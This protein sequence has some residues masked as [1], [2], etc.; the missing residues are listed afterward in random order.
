VHGLRQKKGT[1]Y[2]LGGNANTYSLIR[3]RYPLPP[4]FKAPDKIKQRY[5]TGT[6]ITA[7]PTAQCLL[8]KNTQKR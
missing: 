8:I 1:K 2:K 3:A 5:N 4:L 6:F 7:L